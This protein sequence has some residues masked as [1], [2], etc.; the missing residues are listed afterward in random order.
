MGLWKVGS[1]FSLLV[2]ATAGAQTPAPPPIPSLLEQP[3]LTEAQRAAVDQAFQQI[4]EAAGASVAATPIFPE[5]PPVPADLPPPA[6]DEQT[7]A[8]VEAAF[9]PLAMQRTNLGSLAPSSARVPQGPAVVRET[10]A[11]SPASAASNPGEL[12]ASLSYLDFWPEEK[13][14]QFLRERFVGLE[15]EELP[16]D[17]FLGQVLRASRESVEDEGSLFRRV[18]SVYRSHEGLLVPVRVASS[19][20]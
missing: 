8:R 3:Q 9:V 13:K 17:S 19:Q 20:R 18:R 15:K 2:T 12:A 7:K 16:A 14:Q 4:R 6:F 5:P 1:M 10:Q 11:A